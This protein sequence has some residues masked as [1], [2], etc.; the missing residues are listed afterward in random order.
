M[1]GWFNAGIRSHTQAKGTYF[2]IYRLH[3]EDAVNATLFEVNEFII[4]FIMRESKY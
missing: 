4:I 2:L 1:Y 3:D